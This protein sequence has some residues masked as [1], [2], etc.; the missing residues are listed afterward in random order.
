MK[1]VEHEQGGAYI[2]FTVCLQSIRCQQ[3]LQPFCD[4]SSY[5]LCPR[6]HN[7]R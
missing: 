7:G 4:V 1:Y 5:A 2:V 6:S 3:A